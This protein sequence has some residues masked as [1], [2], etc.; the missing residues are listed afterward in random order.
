MMSIKRIVFGCSLLLFVASISACNKPQS[1]GD[2]STVPENGNQQVAQSKPN[3]QQSPATTAPAMA[4][5]IRYQTPS[6]M[7][8][9]ESKDD[10]IAQEATSLKV[11][12]S[13]RSTRG[14]QPLWDILKRLA[15]L[16]R[17]NVSWASDV[18][19]TVLVDVD[20]NA[21]DDFYEAVDN[22]LRQVDYF[23]EMQ[24]NTIVVK[25]KE[26]RQY[27]VAMPYVSQQYKTGTGGN[28]LGSSEESNNIDGTIQLK[29]NEVTFDL[30]KNIEDNVNEILKVWST[31]A[32]TE[33]ARAVSDNTTT[34]NAQGEISD[35]QETTFSATRRR[36]EN[37][38]SFLIDKS[39]GMVTATAPRPLLDRLDSYFNTL[40]TE[41]YKQITIEA[42]II[43]VQL[44]EE[45][46][47]GINWSEVLKNFPV[48]GTVNFGAGGQIYPSE[49]ARF[50]SRV[51]LNPL[52][53]TAFIN[54]LKEQGDAKIL[55]NPKL[56]VMNG[57]PALITV[58]RNITY[59]DSIE[60]DVDDDTNTTTYTVNTERV[61]SG[62]GMALTATILNNNEIIMNLVPV[63]SELV[64]PIEYK[65]I[66]ANGATVGLPIV[67]VREMST[68]VKMLDGEMLV[69]G[70]L[71]S[72][73]NDNTSAFAPGLGSIPVLKYLFGYEQKVNQK[74]ELIILLRPQII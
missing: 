24:G 13:I 70:G 26:T 42:K 1:A 4:L 3:F 16:K 27:H 21:N 11:G 57:Q 32:V 49:G 22:L 7:V 51:T 72:N 69:I 37:Q 60:S 63:T 17:M 47:I 43:E 41:L 28:V 35:I 54:A 68:T 15:A 5:P 53:F 12:A 25:Y 33:E 40:R 52:N 62:I 58:G 74:R 23:H 66:G 73:I 18:D 61:L 55:S 30:W 29:S 36:S 39:I 10:L 59:I 19:Q 38:N 46:N 44:N 34:Q 20:I 50:V 48:S 6:Y 2:P 8:D 9:S 31:D 45:S 64:E 65:D 14:P 56:S 71:I 67:N